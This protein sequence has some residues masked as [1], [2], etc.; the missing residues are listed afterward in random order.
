MQVTS[1][2]SIAV[3]PF[4]NMSSE[5]E[6]E[7]FSDG[8]TEEILNSLCTI[9]GLH[10]T[11]R[12]SSFAYKNQ[13]ID[14]R[15]IGRKLNV[16]HILEG[17]IRKQGENIRITA[18]LI[19]AIDGYH[20][21]S[22]TWQK[23][24]KNIFSVQEE[25]AV[26][27]TEKIKSGLKNTNQNEKTPLDN[28]QAI[29]LYLRAK[30]LTNSWNQEE[31]KQ[32]IEYYNQVLKLIP[33][34]A[35]AYVGLAHCYTLLGTIGQMKFSEASKHIGINIQ[36]AY[37]LNPDISE[38]Y[39]SFAKK[40]FWYEWDLQK[41]M[42]NVDKALDLAPSNSEALYFK[43]MI[44]AT[45]GKFDEALDY[46]N[47]CQRLN[48]LSEQINYFFG[49][50]YG[51]MSDFEKAIEYYDKNIEVNPRFH[52]QYR[53]KIFAL[54]NNEKFDD[55]LNE[56]ENFP[57][58]IIPNK[59][60]AV[61]AMSSY[62]YACKGEKSKALEIVS[63]LEEC[64]AK[65]SDNSY[66]TLSLAYTYIKLNEFERALELLEQGISKR[67]MYFLFILVDPPWAVLKDNA[68]FKE[69]T[70][71]I[72]LPAAAE[73]TK[74][75]KSGL[76]SKQSKEIL[77]HLKKVIGDKELYLNP[78]LNLSDLSEAI[79]VSTNKLSQVLNESISKNFY[80][81]INDFRLEH[82]IKLFNNPKNKQF[83]MLSLAYES[84]FNSKS[85]FNAFFKKSKGLSPSEYFKK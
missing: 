11:A 3:L 68:R 36:K 7:Y 14:I 2:Y 78:Q 66:V 30:Y 74:Y 77:E 1:K 26:N 33:N 64:L 22:D 85:T 41:A 46:L 13:N 4:V 83:T 65:V 38:I 37:E 43:G 31:T 34:Y 20:I 55:A 28:S 63:Y 12:T 67:S 49:T 19:K 25:I 56:L 27:I 73:Q 6:N 24:L 9:E 15:E 40:N 84:G 79:D 42:E 17:S 18:Q 58:G 16:A 23:E 76:T 80:E 51:F 60:Y 8:V 82:F 71:K 50:V 72:I 59:E 29:D 5:K 62:Y 61:K 39:I 10:V 75:K 48:P 47:R 81:Y 45:Y 32:A 70:K 57:E 53:S 21:W 54:C 69:A 44:Y 35:Q 52:S